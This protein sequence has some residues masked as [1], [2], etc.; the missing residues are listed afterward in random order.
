MEPML[1]ILEVDS[2]LERP[3]MGA[4]RLPAVEALALPP[5]VRTRSVRIWRWNLVPVAASES[6]GMSSLTWTVWACWRRLSRREKRLEQ[7][8]WKGRSPVCFL[9][10]SQHAVPFNIGPSSWGT[11]QPG[12]LG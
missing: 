4:P 7:W 12:Q 9:G 1:A 6:I 11:G 8:H 2:D 3:R 5:P 10:P